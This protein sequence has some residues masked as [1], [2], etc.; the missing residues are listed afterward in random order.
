MLVISATLRIVIVEKLWY[1]LVDLV[2][3]VIIALIEQLLAQ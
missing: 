3:M 2:I 1:L